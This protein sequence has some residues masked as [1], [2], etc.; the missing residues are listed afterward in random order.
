MCQVVLVAVSTV[1]ASNSGG[2]A[3]SQLENLAGDNCRRSCSTGKAGQGG[4][5]DEC[6]LPV[7][8]PAS[9]ENSCR[10][11]PEEEDHVSIPAHQTI[12]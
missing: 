4:Q 6:D 10:P 12:M 2:A 7:A 1:F 9:L 3:A 5:A 11:Y 8:L